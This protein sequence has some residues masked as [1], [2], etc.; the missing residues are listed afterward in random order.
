MGTW[1]DDNDQLTNAQHHRNDVKRTY[2]GSRETLR[3]AT[4]ANT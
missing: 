1:D 4:P 3:K 2:A